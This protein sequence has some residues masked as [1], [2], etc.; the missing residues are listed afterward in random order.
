MGAAR[1]F[2]SS[3]LWLSG[4]VVIGFLTTGLVA[5]SIV[6]TRSAGADAVVPVDELA[7]NLAYLAD[8]QPQLDLIAVRQA[9]I[10]VTNSAAELRHLGAQADGIMADSTMLAAV[11][12]DWLT[13]QRTERKLIVGVNVPFD[14]LAA[15]TGSAIPDGPGYVQA[16]LGQAFS[17]LLWRVERGSRMRQSTG[18]DVIQDTVVLLGV[19]DFS[20]DKLLAARAALSADQP[21]PSGAPTRSS[22]RCGPGV[23]RPRRIQHARRAPCD[24]RSNPGHRSDWRSASPWSSASAPRRLLSPSSRRSGAVRGT[25]G[26]RE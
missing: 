21:A 11:D 15:A 2:R 14:Q 3:P 20:M 17:S 8:P 16:W 19:V 18:S 4:L 7:L 25:C 12:R 22:T 23:Q 13:P 5:S 9:G 1:T 6:A 10:S 24:V 26:N